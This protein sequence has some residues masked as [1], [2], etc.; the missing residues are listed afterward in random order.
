MKKPNS[1]VRS[2]IGQ[3]VHRFVPPDTAK[4]C[5]IG[6]IIFD[7]MPGFQAT[8]DGDVVFYA[9]C[10][11]IS[12]LTHVSII[13]GYADELLAKEGI[14]DSSVF[15]K[16]AAKT[17]KHQKITHISLSLEAQRPLLKEAIPQM[18][19]KIA[20]VLKISEDLVGITAIS[21]D[22]LTECGCGN[23]VSCLAVITTQEDIQ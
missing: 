10:N 21:A 11:A 4:P 6:G 16:E 17:L 23:G 5:I 19:K 22:A 14:T 7:N 20:Q 9:L 3:S 2:A 12:T 1:I 13:G 8:S 15:L 18:R